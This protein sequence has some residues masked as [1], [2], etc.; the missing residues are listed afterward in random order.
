MDDYVARH[1][2]FHQSQIA[3][4]LIESAGMVAEN[5]QRAQRGAS[6]AYTEDAF[7]ELINKYGLGHNDAVTNILQHGR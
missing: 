6:M 4:A 3:A 7:Q 5:M 2:V 1:L